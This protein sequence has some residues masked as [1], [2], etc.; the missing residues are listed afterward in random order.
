MTGAPGTRI[1]R[2][3]RRETSEILVG[4]V[5]VSIATTKPRP[6]AA[7]SV[8]AVR[9]AEELVAERSGM[10]RREIR[11]AS[12]LPSGRPVASGPLGPLMLSVSVSHVAGMVAAAVARGA[13]VGIDVVDVTTVRS[14]IDFWLDGADR[15]GGTSPG[16]LWAAKEAAYK[17]AGIDA[18]FRPLAVE[19]EAD[20]EGFTW[21]LRDRWRGARGAGRFVVAGRHVVAVA[22]ATAIPAAGEGASCS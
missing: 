9:L 21:R 12:L 2:D 11:V 13:S 19:V 16:M 20:D 15:P 14:G 4:E 10:P 18:P 3:A 17:A 1:G 5:A 6:G 8:V 22:C 7:L